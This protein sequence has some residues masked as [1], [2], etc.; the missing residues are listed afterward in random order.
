MCSARASAT[1]WGSGTVR[2]DRGVFGHPE[3]RAPGEE[4]RP[5]L[6][7]GLLGA[8]RYPILR[9]VPVLALGLEGPLWSAG[10]A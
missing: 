3:G 8:G 10:W 5:A 4:A 7:E 9:A 1:N 2:C 6:R